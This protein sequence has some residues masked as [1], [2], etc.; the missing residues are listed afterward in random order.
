MATQPTQGKTPRYLQ[1]LPTSANLHPI[2]SN[3][4]SAYVQDPKSLQDHFEDQE[5]VHNTSADQF[6]EN[7][8]E[9]DPSEEQT[10]AHLQEPQGQRE[11]L[12][13]SGELGPYS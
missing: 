12:E 13:A 4:A 3:L 6:S 11:P 5:V 10:P 1:P 7:D 8:N 2:T 9:V